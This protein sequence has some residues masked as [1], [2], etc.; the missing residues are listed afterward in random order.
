MTQRYYMKLARLRDG[1]CAQV[2]AMLVLVQ[3]SGTGQVFLT[4][5][6]FQDGGGVLFL[7]KNYC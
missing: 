2:V 6:K 1:A 4:A 5:T 7:K 3:G